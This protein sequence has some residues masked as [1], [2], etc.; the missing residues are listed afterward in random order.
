VLYRIV[1]NLKVADAGAGQDFY[2]D[3]LGL[4]GDPP[5]TQTFASAGIYTANA[6]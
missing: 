2:V 4:V 1:P 5:R 6:N 3:F